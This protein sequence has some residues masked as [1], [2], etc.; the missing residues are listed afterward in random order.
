MHVLQKVKKII[1][2]KDQPLTSLKPYSCPNSAVTRI[3]PVLFMMFGSNIAEIISPFFC[4]YDSFISNSGLQ[5]T[6]FVQFTVG[7]VMVQFCAWFKF[8]HSLCSELII[9]HYHTQE[10]RKIKIKPRINLNHNSDKHSGVSV[11]A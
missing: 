2:N 8:Y 10:Q 9:I 5:I 11:T 6:F 7:D 3:R 1:N 4:Y